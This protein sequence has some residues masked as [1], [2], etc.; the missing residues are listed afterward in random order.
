MDVEGLRANA[1]ATR[2]R[3]SGCRKGQDD[4]IT[5]KYR[6]DIQYR[7]TP[8][9]RRTAITFRAIYGDGDD[10]EQAYEP[11]T[12]TGT[13][14][15]FLLNP[16]NVYH[17]KRPGAASS[18]VRARAARPHGGRH[19]LYNIGMPS[20]KGHLRAESAVRVSRRSARP[21]RHRSGQ[22]A[23]VRSTATSG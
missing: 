3:S 6:V 13:R 19:V 5:N 9:S 23:P 17:W 2:P 18:A 10:L 4:F 20:P 21:Q 7:G 12:N 11:D 15:V 22:R 8:G 14:S 16:A 1:P